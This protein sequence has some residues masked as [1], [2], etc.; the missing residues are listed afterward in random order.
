MKWLYEKLTDLKDEGYKAFQSKLVPN[1][2]PDAI[3]GVRT[4]A[5]RALAKEI[6]RGE[7]REEFLSALPH[8]YYEENLIH[9][10]VIS[11]ERDFDEC[12]RLHEE[13][14]PFVDCWPVSDQS[15]PKVFGKNHTALIP[16]LKKWISSDHVYTARFGIRILMNEFL[17]K[18]F[19]EEYSDLVANKKGDDYY[20]KMMIAWYFATALCKNYDEIVKYLEDRRLE[21][22]V[23]KK[24]I[25]KAME[26]FRISDEHK[27]Y[28]KSLK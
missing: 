24:T 8:G 19:K 25:Q 20:L 10:F 28:L 27:A 11:E 4:P 7:K 22:W 18:D 17:G 15:S 21:E 13:F 3:I 23:H 26:S 2:S 1:V 14:L 12:I 16:Y 6:N 9:M 5:L